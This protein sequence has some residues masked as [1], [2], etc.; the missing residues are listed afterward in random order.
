MFCD[1]VRRSRSATSS[2]LR[3]AF[4][5]VRASSSFASPFR[6]SLRP[7]RRREASSAR[8]PVAFLT[9]PV[10]L[11]VRP[12]SDAYP[13]AAGS[14]WARARSTA[15]ITA[16]T[17][18]ASRFGSGASACGSPRRPAQRT[19]CR[20]SAGGPH[21]VGGVGP[22]RTTDGVRKAVARCATPVSP[23]ATQSAAATTAA[24][25]AR[26][27]RPARTASPARPAARA[28]SSASA[29]SPGPDR[30]STRL[31]S[32]HAHISYAVFCL[33]KKILWFGQRAEGVTGW[34]EVRL[35]S[36]PRVLRA[37]GGVVVVFFNH[38]ATTEIYTLSLHDALPISL[39]SRTRDYTPRRRP[40]G[41]MRW[42]LRELRRERSEEHTS[43]LQSRQ[44]LV[45]RLLLEKKN[46]ISRRSSF[47][48]F[49]F[50][51]KQI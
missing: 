22:N 28:T 8:S 46:S 6:S 48:A 23:Q 12:M 38:P 42:L 10:S 31:N 27:V 35:G 37:A 30:K 29:R 39:A 24:S 20:A 32:S 9:L 41:C 50:K 13:A 4:S 15:A 47:A 16:G 36:L 49:S 1:Q 40:G 2:A 44:Y 11:S 21:S 26:S 25:V 33:K 18:I 14:N 17:P 7:S 34:L 3:S 19:W 5:C 43:E 51:K 45:C